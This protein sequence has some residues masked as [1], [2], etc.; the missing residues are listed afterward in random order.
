MA[1]RLLRFAIIICALLVTSTAVGCSSDGRGWPE[2]APQTDPAPVGLH[3]PAIG[4]RANTVMDL[5]VD[6][7]GVVEVPPVEQPERVGWYSP[8]V[9]PGQPGPLVMLGHVN[10]GGRDGVFA[11]LHELKTGDQITVPTATGSHIY[12]VDRVQTV[13]KDAFPTSEVY[14]NTPGPELRLIT[15]GGQWDPVAE[16]YEDQIIVYAT[17]A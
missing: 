11:R 6:D 4:V 16:S 1:R 15:C 5:G 12:L 10:G 7:N 13:D 9:A 17:E 3:I 14:G 8:G 2:P